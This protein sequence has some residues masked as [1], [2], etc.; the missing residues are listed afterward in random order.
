M[1][2]G[3]IG[4]PGHHCQPA[5]MFHG[6]NCEDS[7]FENKELR[8]ALDDEMLAAKERLIEKTYQGRHGWSA[9]GK[10]GLLQ[11]GS[12]YFEK[13]NSRDEEIA[14]SRA[15]IHLD[16][17]SEARCRCSGKTGN[18]YDPANLSRFKGSGNE[19]LLPSKCTCDDGESD[20]VEDS[21]SDMESDSRL[22]TIPISLIRLELESFWETL[23]SRNFSQGRSYFLTA[24]QIAQGYLRKWSC[25]SR[26]RLNRIRIHRLHPPYILNLDFLD[27]MNADIFSSYAAG[28]KECLKHLPVRPHGTA[29]GPC[30]AHC[31]IHRIRQKRSCTMQSFPAASGA[32]PVVTNAAGRIYSFLSMPLAIGQNGISSTLIFCVAAVKNGIGG[33]VAQIGIIIALADGKDDFRRKPI[34]FYGLHRRHDAVI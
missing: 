2:P 27:P 5:L 29:P 6:W 17:P 10:A 25:L 33:R 3:S 7:H 31:S 23:H 4:K 11:D 16:S 21:D 1:I 15:V 14:N 13:K 18:H 22:K 30:L 12:G 24:G 26:Y 34:A 20:Q 8:E 28:I 32:F 19:M 9:A